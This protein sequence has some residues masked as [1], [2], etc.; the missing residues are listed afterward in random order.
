MT[1]NKV[2]QEEKTDKEIK[3]YH[4]KKLEKLA[5]SHMGD[6][7]QLDEPTEEQKRWLLRR[8]TAP[9]KTW[10]AFEEWQN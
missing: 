1:M 10:E 6:I 5:L 9:A 8:L 3:E 7:P 2:I 4:V